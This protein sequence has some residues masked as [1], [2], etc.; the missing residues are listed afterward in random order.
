[1]YTCI[2]IYIGILLYSYYLILTFLRWGQNWRL[3]QSWWVSGC[4][5]HEAFL[6]AGKTSTRLPPSFD[7]LMQHFVGP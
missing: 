7:P 2:Y 6:A 1:M 3:V 4:R 5:S